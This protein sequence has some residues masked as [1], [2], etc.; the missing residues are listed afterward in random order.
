MAFWLPWTMEIQY[1]MVL[2]LLLRICLIVYGEWQDKTMVVKFTDVDYHVFTDAAEYMTKG[3]SPYMRST[4]R[5]TPVLAWMLQPNILLT[6]LYGKLL[7]VMFDV[8]TGYLIYKINC[9]KGVSS[10]MTTVCAVCWLLNPIPMTVSSR[11]NAESIM[12]FLVL[13]FIQLLQSHQV[14][15]AGI[16]YAIAVHFK[17]YPITYALPVYLLLGRSYRHVNKEQHC[18]ETLIGLLPTKDRAVFILTSFLTLAVLTFLCYEWYGWEF[19]QHTYLHHITRQDIRHNFSIYF[20]MLYLQ[21]GS[22]NSGILGLLAFLPQVVLIF[23]FSFKFFKQT[24]LVFFLNTFA[25]VNFNK[26]CTSQY[27]LWYLCLFPLI[28]PHLQHIKLWLAG[29]VILLWFSAQNLWLLAAYYLEFEGINTFMQVWFAGL[30]FFYVN[31]SFLFIIIDNYRENLTVSCETAIPET[32]LKKTV[33]V[34]PP[35]VVQDKVHEDRNKFVQRKILIK[36]LRMPD[37]NA[38]R[39]VTRSQTERKKKD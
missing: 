23:V 4:Y 11:G 33:A 34:M 15:L 16:V 6:P 13:L 7:F 5:Y 21:I 22:G 9:S 32:L 31:C 3:L 27:F 28:L 36:T 37:E 25:F 8:L 10:K 30:V 20:Y 19:L 17:V 38:S 18:R 26:V 2:A 1:L 12:S 14:A 29:L 24:S 39:I 35:R